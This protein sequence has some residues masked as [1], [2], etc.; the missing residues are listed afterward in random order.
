MGVICCDS[1]S[2]GFN[3]NTECGCRVETSENVHCYQACPVKKNKMKSF[4][5]NF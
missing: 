4:R 3:D 2:S 5:S 1:F